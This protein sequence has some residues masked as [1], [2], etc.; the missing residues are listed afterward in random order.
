[1][2][3]GDRPDQ[4]GRL[5]SRVPAKCCRGCRS[6]GQLTAWTPDASFALTPGCMFGKLRPR[7]SDMCIE[8]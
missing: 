5:G 1:M 8:K 7:D 6:F 4:G 2:A 3:R